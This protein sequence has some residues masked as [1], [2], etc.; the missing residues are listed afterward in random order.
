M[1]KAV[2]GVVATA[3]EARSRSL[4]GSSRSGFFRFGKKKAD[5]ECDHKH[6]DA[7]NARSSGVVIPRRT[8]AQH[9]C[10][11]FVDKNAAEVPIMRPPTLVAKTAAGAAQMERKYFRQVFAEVAELRDDEQAAEKDAN[12]KSFAAGVVELK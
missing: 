4:P 1:I 11:T 10:K 2:P 3:D 6:G 7:G 8:P 5:R 9:R 12:G